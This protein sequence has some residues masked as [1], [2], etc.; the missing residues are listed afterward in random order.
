[1]TAT[2]ADRRPVGGIPLGG[3]SLAERPWAL[4][5]EEG[6]RGIDADWFA[7]LPHRGA[8]RW[9][10][11]VSDN[12]NSRI[13]LELYAPAK[14]LG[15]ARKLLLQLRLQWP[16]LL[17]RDALIPIRHDGVRQLWGDV[18]AAAGLPIDL[19][20]FISVGTPGPTQKVTVLLVDPAGQRRAIMKLAVEPQA[21][22][23][24]RHEAQMLRFMAGRMP[25][26]VV[27]A[28]LGEFETSFGWVAVQSVV[29]TR[30]V[31]NKLTGR[32]W[33][34]LSSLLTETTTSIS[35]SLANGR[36]LHR[37]DQL[38]SSVGLS[39]EEHRL[40]AAVAARLA[41]DVAP[42][43]GSIVHGDFAPWNIGLG[44]DG[45]ELSLFDWEYG[46][47]CGLPMLDVIHFVLRTGILVEGLHGEALLDSVDEAMGRP[48]AAD[49]QCRA[50]VRASDLGAYVIQYLL[51]Q[52]V[53]EGEQ[54][55]QAK[56][57]EL[58]DLL[59]L[60]ALAWR[61]WGGGR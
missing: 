60:L 57:K 39:L 35:A 3:C 1:M 25:G 28:L 23:R 8:P 50:G 54:H 31:G 2:G 4:L 52:L 20:L 26:K 48:A 44:A 18:F 30:G 29:P 5:G 32:H 59:H 38:R 15:K 41:D 42:V 34:L 45:S 17:L 6:G 36:I 19:R 12:V 13:G 55:Q 61:R 21:E 14:L 24:V 10:V 22:E 49:Y 47:E 40:V 46:D 16:R 37:W 53:K 51:L 33:Q 58:R 7:A 11:P 9:V 27:P 43:Q 56:S